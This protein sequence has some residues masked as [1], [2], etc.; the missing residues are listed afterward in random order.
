M[1]CIVSSC[2]SAIRQY[3]L[4][5]QGKIKIKRSF[6]EQPY[7]CACVHLHLHAM[8]SVRNGPF[9]LRMPQIHI[10]APIHGLGPRLDTYM[11]A[12]CWL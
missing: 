2:S 1:L 3:V 11:P 6:R 10:L 12:L 4:C 7:A 9:V 8:Y 5:V